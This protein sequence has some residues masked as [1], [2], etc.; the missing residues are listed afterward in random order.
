MKLVTFGIDR[1][2]NLIM[3]FP[4]FIQPYTQ[5]LLIL[6]QLETVPVPIVDKNSNAQSFAELKIKN[7]ILL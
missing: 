3:Q 1:D 4:V 2:R 7:H 6:Y 5:Q